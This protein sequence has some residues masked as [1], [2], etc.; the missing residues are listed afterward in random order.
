MRNA[1]GMGRSKKTAARRITVP[2]YAEH[3]AAIEEI[4]AA[5]AERG[6]TLSTADVVRQAILVARKQ[7]CGDGPF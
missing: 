6:H 2:L 7:L 3:R 5:E 4:R 1:E